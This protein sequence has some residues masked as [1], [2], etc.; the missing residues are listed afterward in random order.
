MAV[1]DTPKVDS[2]AKR[3]SFAV[4]M[5][6]ARLWRIAARLLGRCD[7]PLWPAA[8]AG[9]NERVHLQ[10]VQV[11]VCGATCSTP[12]TPSSVVR[13]RLL[14]TGCLLGYCVMVLG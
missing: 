14:E 7:L 1:A 10:D 8:L 11:A 12:S 6:M 2:A 5:A 9:G 4:C 13:L 3:M